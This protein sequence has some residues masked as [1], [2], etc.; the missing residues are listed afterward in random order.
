MC[1]NNA[2]SFSCGYINVPENDIS[3]PITTKAMSL[4]LTSDGPEV[5]VI[6]HYVIKFVSDMH[7]SCGFLRFLSPIKL[8]ATTYN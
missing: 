1:G 2:V 3:V 8:T 7:E 4:N 5:Y 6:Q